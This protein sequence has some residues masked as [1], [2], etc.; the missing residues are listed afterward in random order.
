[1]GTDQEIEFTVDRGVLSVLQCRTA[2]TRIAEAMVDFV[3]PGD[4]TTRGL[5]ICGGAFRGMVAFDE[6]DLKELASC[7]RA[8]REDVD[9]LLLLLQNPTPEDIPWIISAGG[10]LTAKGGSTS[11]AAVAANGIED[12][13]FAAVMS[14]IH[15][16]VDAENHQA[17]IGDAAGEVRHS[18]G[19]GDIISIHGTTGEVFIGSRPIEPLELK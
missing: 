3:D 12:R 1:M 17:V 14:A 10:L 7:G 5:G 19:K 9:G 2:E 6:N 4:P 13:A 16:R 15:L 8:D 11:H 18:I